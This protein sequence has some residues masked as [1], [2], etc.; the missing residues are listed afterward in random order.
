MHIHPSKL[1]SCRCACD[2]LTENG[3]TACRK[4]LNRAR[5][6]RRRNRKEVIK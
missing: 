6:L 4:C 3:S 1:D 2:A 5:W